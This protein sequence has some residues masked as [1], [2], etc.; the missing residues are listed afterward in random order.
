[1]KKIIEIDDSLFEKLEKIQKDYSINSLTPVISLVLTL[2]VNWF[3]KLEGIVPTVC[4][5]PL[6]N[7]DWWTYPNQGTGVDTD[8]VTV[9]WDVINAISGCIDNERK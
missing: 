3:R 9:K 8:N 5:P 2:G 4:S 6:V 7:V 1:M